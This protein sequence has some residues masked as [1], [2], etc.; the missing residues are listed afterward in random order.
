MNDQLPHYMINLARRPDRLAR[1]EA[2]LADLS[3]TTIR[4]DAVDMAEVSERALEKVVLARGPI[5]PLALGDRACTASHFR[6][7]EDFLDTPQPAAVFLEDDVGFAKDYAAYARDIAWI[8][9]DAQVIKFE[10]AGTRPSKKLMGPG[11]RTPR[12]RMLHR[13]YSRHAGGAAYL[14]T[15]KGAEALYALRGY[16]DVPVDHMLFS[17]NV[18][19]FARQRPIYQLSP[20]IA[21]QQV[22]ENGSDIDSERKLRKSLVQ[23]VR[24]G[25]LEVNCVPRQML[26]MITAGARWRS[27]D[28]AE[29]PE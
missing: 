3:L 8:P 22:V 16:A 1:M 12:G 19:A 7:W 13:L 20:A 17:P 14:L 25:Y 26:K 2:R 27:I 10:R 5:G 11:L 24:R 29:T 6:A 15:R 21:R 4:V 9:S 18:S 23:R 28:F